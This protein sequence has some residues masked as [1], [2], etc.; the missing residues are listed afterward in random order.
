MT[1]E[2]IKFEIATRV[3]A[4]MGLPTDSK[5]YAQLEMEVQLLRD[6]LINRPTTE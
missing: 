1:V 5:E 6:Q 3:F 2:E 4:Q